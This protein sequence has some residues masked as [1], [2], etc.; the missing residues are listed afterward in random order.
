M[1][2]VQPCGERV[3]MT[4]WVHWR[5]TRG[6]RA[7]VSARLPYRIWPL[8]RDYLVAIEINY[9]V[10][11]WTANESSITWPP[12]TAALGLAAAPRFLPY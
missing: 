8:L 4:Q 6:P 9:G 5:W 11:P 3:M 7:R 2:V 10:H 1:D 12:Q